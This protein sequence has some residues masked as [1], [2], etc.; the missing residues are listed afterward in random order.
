[1]GHENDEMVRRVYGHI[2][3]QKQDDINAM[4]NQFFK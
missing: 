4:M 1:M 2:M 3:E